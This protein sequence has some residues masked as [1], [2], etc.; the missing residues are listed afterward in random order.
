[1]EQK[2]IDRINELARKKKTEGLTPAELD[3]EY[4]IRKMLGSTNNQE[5][6]EQLISLME[7][8]NSNADFFARING[9]MAAFEK[10]GFSM[11]GGKR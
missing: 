10:D 7:K 11:G 6:A 8:T 2:K 5:T 1:M 3:G 9:W 4:Q